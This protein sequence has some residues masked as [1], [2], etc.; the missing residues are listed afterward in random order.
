MSRADWRARLSAP[1]LGRIALGLA[2]GAA[3]G[4]AAAAAGMPLAWMI[5]A[6]FACV[7]ASVAG[8]PVDVPLWLRTRF[9]VILGL[10]LA[11]GFGGLAPGEMLRWPVS[12]ALALLYVP[13]SM[14]L[15]FHYYRRVAG[16]DFL[17]AAF[18]A[19]PGGLTIVVTAA[20][21]LG[22][23][24]RRVALTQSIRVALVVAGAP[25]LALV[26]LG[27]LPVRGLA[28]GPGMGWGQMALLLA[29]G[30]AAAWG[31]GRLR[32]PVA[33]L[34]GPM[35]ASGLLRWAGLIE[36]NLQVWL[37]D[38]A[39][40]VTGASIGSRFGGTGWRLLGRMTLVTLGGTGV[41]LAVSAVFAALAGWWTGAGPVAALLAFAPGGIAEMALIALAID[42]DPGFVAVHHAARIMLILALVPALAAGIRRR[43]QRRR[44]APPRPPRG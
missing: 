42:A 37:V 19:V 30:F 12:V 18:S 15:V 11:E 22:A 26:F 27:T 39:L 28:E 3:G 23:D 9:L 43:E 35:I 13:V 8:L 24:E 38:V 32:V 34:I 17:T 44:G 29:A 6:L 7:L 40:L 41:M 21:P 1:A 25:A 14:W 10:F 20:G 31:L 36:G 16:E 5:G 33:F 2:A 4:W